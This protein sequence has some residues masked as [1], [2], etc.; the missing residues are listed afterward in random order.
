MGK[1]DLFPSLCDKE[2]KC[3]WDRHGG[4]YPCS[5]GDRAGDDHSC[6]EARCPWALALVPTQA[7]VCFLLSFWLWE[8]WDTPGP[9][10]SMIQHINAACVP[11]TMY[12]GLIR[13][14]PGQG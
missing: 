11:F 8:G 10:K 1:A 3:T 13:P 14:L 2:E 9:P 7:P 5:C 6:C 4:I 12:F